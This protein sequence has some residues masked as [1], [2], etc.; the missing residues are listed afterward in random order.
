MPS[1][2][3]HWPSSCK[4]ASVKTEPE[5]TF[6]RKYYQGYIKESHFCFSLLLSSAAETVA[7]TGP[8]S[9]YHQGSRP[10]TNP[11][12]YTYGSSVTS[13]PGPYSS[14]QSLNSVFER[15]DPNSYNSIINRQLMRSAADPT[16]ASINDTATGNA[17]RGTMNILLHV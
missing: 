6:K 7:S 9:Y 1:F 13:G 8:F 2:L 17:V 5:V 4:Q 14:Q 16:Y 3:M 11:N 12:P 15:E 10:Q